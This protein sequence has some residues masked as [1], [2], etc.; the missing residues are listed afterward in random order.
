[1]FRSLADAMGG[2][3]NPAGADGGNFGG[4]S[5]A[6][7][8]VMAP[9]MGGG[10]QM[11]QRPGLA[12]PSMQAPPMQPPPMMGKPPMGRMPPSMGQPMGQPMPNRQGAP[13]AQR[14]PFP[15]MMQ[16][17]GRGARDMLRNPQFYQSLQQ[18]LGEMGGGPV[19]GGMNPMMNRGMRMRQF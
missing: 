7:N 19:G 2:G 12:G 8:K 15:G 14:K 1:M 11:G 13:I 3:F 6:I 9:P 5:G 10:M 17:F 4:P 18:R 16:R